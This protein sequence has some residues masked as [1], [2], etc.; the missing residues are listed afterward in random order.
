MKF[1][2]KEWSANVGF[3]VF[4]V[5][6][7]LLCLG[8][9]RVWERVSTPDCPDAPVDTV[10]PCTL[11]VV[12]GVADTI[13]GDDILFP[14]FEM[15]V[16]PKH[17]DTIRLCYPGDTTVYYCADSIAVLNERLL[18][19]NERDYTIPEKAISQ[20]DL[21]ATAAAMRALYC[22]GM[23]SVAAVDTIL[24]PYHELLHT[25]RPW[26]EVAIPHK[27]EFFDVSCRWAHWLWNSRRDSLK[28]RGL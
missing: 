6:I 4:I 5:I 21:D 2:S 13:S 15:T 7:G 27:L 16:G 9:G 24:Q 18:A 19:D 23:V 1:W 12:D 20:H 10:L 8:A 22:T 28:A 14:T 26:I 17:P 25:I 3:I 11:R